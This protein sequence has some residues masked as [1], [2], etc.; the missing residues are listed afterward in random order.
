MFCPRC[1]VQNADNASFCRS[2]GANIALVP[3]ALTGQLAVADESMADEGG[4]GRRRRRHKDKGPATME[5]AVRSLFVGVA[6]ICVS[7]SI[8]FWMP[9]GFVWWFWMLIP[10]FGCLGD[11]VGTLLRTRSDQQKLAPPAFRPASAIPSAAHVNELPPRDL[12]GLYTPPASVT[13]ETTRHL[14][15]PPE[16]APKDS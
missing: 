12:S 5:K 1:A 6:F 11:G 3:Q 4:R 2:C 8:L 16:R 10:A 15:A 9:G 13:E 14:G 7:L